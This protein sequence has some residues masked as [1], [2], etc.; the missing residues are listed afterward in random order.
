MLEISNGIIKFTKG[1]TVAFE[2]ELKNADGKLYEMQSGDTLTMTVK[3]SINSGSP[4]ISVT[5]TTTKLKILPVSTKMLEPGKYCYD[6]ELTTADGNVYTI[7][8]IRK[9]NEY[10]LVVF[11]EVTINGE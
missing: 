6:V 4:D 5:S 2:V 10:N 8:G 9:E 1:D 3:K 7:V 11:P